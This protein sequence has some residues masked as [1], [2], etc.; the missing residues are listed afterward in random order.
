MV[1]EVVTE[2]R[3]IA[4]ED[5]VNRYI[6]R[7]YVQGAPDAHIEVRP[8][9]N[10]QAGAHTPVHDHLAWGIVGLY[11]GTQDEDVFARR[12]D[13]RKCIAL[14]FSPGDFFF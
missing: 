4:T 5:D 2:R 6:V 3:V 8:L 1:T 13:C 10:C 12:D 14:P 11:E 7:D 9:L